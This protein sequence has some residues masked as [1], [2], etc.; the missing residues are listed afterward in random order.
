VTRDARLIH[1]ANMAEILTAAMT[2]EYAADILSWR[3]P[4]PYDYYNVA[5]GNAGYCLDPANGVLAVLSGG[6]LTGFRS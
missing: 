6:G 4:A 2:A 5:D 3:Y 1:D